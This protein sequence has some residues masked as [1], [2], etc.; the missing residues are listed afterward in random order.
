MVNELGQTPVR[1]CNDD[2]A[3]TKTA[4]IPEKEE[5]NIS[6]NSIT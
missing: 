6:S 3:I 5:A 2:A 4:A 1:T